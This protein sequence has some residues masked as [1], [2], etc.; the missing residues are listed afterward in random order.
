MRSN[1]DRP[2]Y[3]KW[4]HN[5]LAAR[6]TDC[7]LLEVVLAVAYILIVLQLQKYHVMPILI[8]VAAMYC[9]WLLFASLLT[10]ILNAI[11]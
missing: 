2:L 3:P 1:L 4:H 9:Y 8:A 6:L 11:M 7:I 10:V 5:V